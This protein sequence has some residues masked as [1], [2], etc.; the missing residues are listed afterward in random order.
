MGHKTG[1]RL[2]FILIC[3]LLVAPNVGAFSLREAA[4][5]QAGTTL[6]IAGEAIPGHEA[7]ADMARDFAKG[8]GIEVV[9]RAGE[10]FAAVDGTDLAIVEQGRL[11]NLVREGAIRPWSL[12]LINPALRDDAFKPEIDC[13]AAAWEACRPGGELYGYPYSA[14]AALLW[15]RTDMVMEPAEAQAFETVTER[16]LAKPANP[17][18]YRELV[19]WFHRPDEGLA[20]VGLAG[21]RG[22]APLREWL[23]YLEAFGGA[24][25]E[26]ERVVADSPAA[27]ESL[28]YYRDLLAYAQPDAHEADPGEVARAFARGEVFASVLPARWVG[29]TADATADE[30]GI[31]IVSYGLFPGQTEAPASVVWSQVMTVP[32]DADNPDAAFLFAQ[33]LLGRSRQAWLHK[34]AWSSPRIDVYAELELAVLDVVS[35]KGRA[36]AEGSWPLTRHPEEAAT[37]LA[38]CVQNVL[39]GIKRPAE[40]LSWAAG[41]LRKLD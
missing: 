15:L 10:P 6:V 22:L 26:G 19:E 30:A 28:A 3:I 35:A 13:F 25:Y 4:R 18:R 31:P 37:V 9:V 36:L 41:E 11:P 17:E 39:T 24:V 20:G 12:F 38:V 32:A 16:V 2:F 8:T 7:L 33:W 29:L 34:R 5:P 1:M 23:V 27:V 14:H 21:E 40:A